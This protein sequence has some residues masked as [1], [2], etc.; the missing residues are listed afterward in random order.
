MQKVG[1]TKGEIRKT[2]HS[3]ILLV[4][5]LPLVTAI[6][7]AAFAL[8]LVSNCLKMVVIVHMPTFILSF[9]AT[10]VVFSVLYVIVYLLT[11]REYYNIV[12]S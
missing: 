3:Q 6:V 8:K 7:H 2:I 9:V 12:N 10:C 11:S 1:L 4:F 5:F